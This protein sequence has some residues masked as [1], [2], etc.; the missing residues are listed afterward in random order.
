MG[1]VDREPCKMPGLFGEL[2]IDI[3]HAGVYYGYN[4]TR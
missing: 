3:L 4:N 1:T 2:G